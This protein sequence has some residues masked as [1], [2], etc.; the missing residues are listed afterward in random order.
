MRTAAALLLLSNLCSAGTIAVIDDFSVAATTDGA[1]VQT[2]N[3]G[4]W[5]A[6]RTI[7][8][9][10]PGDATGSITIADGELRMTRGAGAQ[11]PIYIIRYDWAAPTFYLDPPAGRRSFYARML[12][13]ADNGAEPRFAIMETDAASGQL[14]DNLSDGWAAWDLNAS[15]PYLFGATSLTV[16]ISGAGAPPDESW[17]GEFNPLLLH[18]HIPE[19]TTLLLCACGAC[20]LVVMP[21]YGRH[22]RCRA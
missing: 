8:V 9:V 17:S 3:I 18:T 19:P 4:D 15:R 13:T 16:E 20:G 7:A 14:I 12:L 1:A 5:G 11:A 6:T 10:T 21:R 22:E 2:E